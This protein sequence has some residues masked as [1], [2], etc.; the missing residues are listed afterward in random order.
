MLGVIEFKLTKFKK[1]IRIYFSDSSK[2]TIQ[3]KQY[4]NEI[5]TLWRKVI[6]WFVKDVIQLLSVSIKK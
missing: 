1:S 2:D 3:S 4:L 6:C 5:V